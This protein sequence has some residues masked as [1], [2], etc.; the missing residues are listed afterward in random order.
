M[1]AHN[2]MKLVTITHYQANMTRWHF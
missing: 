1:R 2:L